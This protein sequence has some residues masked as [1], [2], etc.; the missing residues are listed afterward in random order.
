M[1]SLKQKISQ[2]IIPALPVNRRV[3]D[4]LRFEGGMFFTMSFNYIFPWRFLKILKLRRIKNINLNVGSGGYGRQQGWINIDAMAHLEDIDIAW[5]L[6]RKLPFSC[7]SVS[8][9]FAEHVLEH[10]EFREDMVRVILEFFRVLETKGR[11]R[12]IVPDCKRYLEA[13]V[14]GQDEKWAE[15]GIATL[16]DDMPTR[17]TMVNHV[18]QQNG[19]HYFGYDFETMKWLLEKSGFVDIEELTY[20]VSNDKDLCIDRSEHSKYSLY[21]EAVKP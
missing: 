5:D 18:F 14:S 13:Y 19:E 8:R 1:S 10:I 20:M 3:F 2:I 9:I 7:N 4:I 16:P 12:I 11:V 15:L 6:R 21:V 17:M